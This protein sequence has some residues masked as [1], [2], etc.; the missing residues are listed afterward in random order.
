M[1]RSLVR[2][3]NI[4]INGADWERIFERLLGLCDALGEA[5]Q[6]IPLAWRPH[7]PTTCSQEQAWQAWRQQEAEHI[8]DI[9]AAVRE[10]VRTGRLVD[11]SP[12]AVYFLGVRFQAAIRHLES[13][14]ANAI[15]IGRPVSFVPFPP[16][17]VDAYAEWLL[18]EWGDDH[19]GTTVFPEAVYE[20]RTSTIAGVFLTLSCPSPLCPQ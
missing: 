13:V 18:T 20:S 5:A 3:N 9:D 4:F 14:Y 12:E 16:I 8:E 17:S 7:L 10:L 6:G 2:M 15:S 19:A 11:P 1:T